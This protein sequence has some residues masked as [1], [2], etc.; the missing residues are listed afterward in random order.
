M[1]PSDIVNTQ[2][3]GEVN[4]MNTKQSSKS[5]HQDQV[6]AQET[7]III[8]FMVSLL[9]LPKLNITTVIICRSK[10]FGSR[11]IF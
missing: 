8:N 2:F 3:M 9:N 7:L 4:G 11:D 6:A 1:I 10:T 5:F